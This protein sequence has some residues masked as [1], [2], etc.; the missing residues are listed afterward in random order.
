MRQFSIEDNH[1]AE[2][3][4]RITALTGQ[5]KTEAVIRALELYEGSLL[6]DC[7]PYLETKKRSESLKDERSV[8]VEEN[9]Q[10]SSLLGY[11]NALASKPMSSR[12]REEVDAQILAERNAWDK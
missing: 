7:N 12:S 6:A 2:L 3:L 4:D 9:R 5:D 10:I 8:G 11:L 1:A